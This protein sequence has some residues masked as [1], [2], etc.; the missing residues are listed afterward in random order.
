MANFFLG[1]VALWGSRGTAVEFSGGSANISVV[2]CTVAHAGLHG[3]VVGDGGGSLVQG[4][5]VSGTGGRGVSVS[6]GAPRW[7]LAP[8]GDSVSD[9]TVHDFERV[10][11]TYAFGVAAEGPGVV[12]QRNEVFNS[13]HACATVQGSNA[14]FRWNVLHHCTMDTFDNAALY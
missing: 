3:I 7:Q 6:S 13:G 11:L 9:N 12:V 10:C 1:G 14:L 8:S 2:N 4:N 5:A